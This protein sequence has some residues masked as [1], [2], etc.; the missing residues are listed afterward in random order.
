MKHPRTTG[1]SWARWRVGAAL[2]ALALAGCGTPRPVLTPAELPLHTPDP[3][4]FT[5]HWRLDQTAEAVVAEGVLE[6]T[7]LDRFS[8]VTLEL[9]GVDAQGSVVSRG[10]T[11]ALPRDFTGATPWPFTIRVRPA[12]GETRF[13]LSVTDALPKVSPGR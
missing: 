6:S 1:G 3:R 13:L 5:L 2:I 10:R 8:Q 12:G 11:T 7:R 4:G 9:A